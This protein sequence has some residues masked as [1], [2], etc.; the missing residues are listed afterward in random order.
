PSPAV[1]DYAEL[2]LRLGWRARDALE[3]SLVGQNL[4][5]DSHAEF[6]P[7]TPLRE[8]VERGFYGKVVWRF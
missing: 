2:D 5:H 4:L 7:A 8:E 1:E 6:G 3:L